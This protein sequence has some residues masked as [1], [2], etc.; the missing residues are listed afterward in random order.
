MWSVSSRLPTSSWEVTSRPGEPLYARLPC[1]YKE[2]WWANPSFRR[3]DNGLPTDVRHIVAHVGVQAR[4]CASARVRVSM[5]ASPVL[6]QPRGTIRSLASALV[7]SNHCQ[8]LYKKP[9]HGAPR[10]GTGA[11]Q[12]LGNTATLLSCGRD[13]YT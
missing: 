9:S 1:C 11:W 4:T 3:H 2:R 6:L 12:A 7:C 13:Q 8:T 5:A 10:V